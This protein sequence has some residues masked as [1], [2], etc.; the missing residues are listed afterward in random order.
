MRTAIL[1]IIYVL[2]VLILMYAVIS[3]IMVIPYYDCHPGEVD[4]EDQS[5]SNYAVRFFFS[6]VPFLIMYT[7]SFL[8]FLIVGRFSNES[9][10]DMMIQSQWLNGGFLVYYEYIVKGSFKNRLLF[11][12]ALFGIS[13]ASH[14]VCAICFLLEVLLFKLCLFV[15]IAL[16]GIFVIEIFILSAQHANA[17]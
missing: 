16:S 12:L 1:T 13:F 9:F 15:W 2:A 5:I 4:I 3:F 8:L 6:W 7:V 17:Y 11:L 14:L 10:Q